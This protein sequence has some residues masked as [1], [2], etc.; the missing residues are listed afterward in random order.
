M[1]T[2]IFTDKAKAPGP[3][4]L[5]TALG[6]T[7][8]LWQDLCELTVSKYPKAVSEWYFHGAKWGW[9]FRIKDK[10]R[11]IVYLLPR[12]RYFL[13]AFV[14]GERA[15]EKVMESTVAKAIKDDLQA[16]RPY[17]EGRGIRIEVKDQKTLKDMGLLVDIKLAY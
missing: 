5:K 10:K 9:N 12:E 11:A 17:A 7:H 6:A 2:S 13:A 16:A 15:Y 14:F 4:D 8:Q 3:S 1:D